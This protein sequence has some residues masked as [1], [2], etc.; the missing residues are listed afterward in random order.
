MSGRHSI[1]APDTK[2]T[3]AKIQPNREGVRLSGRER[4]PNEPDGVSE[5]LAFEPGGGAGIKR[6]D[7]GTG[8]LR[9]IHLD[10]VSDA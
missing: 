8:Q 6:L 9:H 7:L 2:L 4:L 5:G 10:L 3:R 1:A